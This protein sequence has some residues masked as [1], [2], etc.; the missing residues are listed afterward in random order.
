MATATETATFV[1]EYSY[2]AT[3]L[4]YL[5]PRWY[6]F[7]GVEPFSSKEAAEAFVAAKEAEYAER[8]ASPRGAEP[9]MFR[10]RTVQPA[11]E[12]FDEDAYWSQRYWADQ[13][14]AVRR[15]EE[16]REEMFRT[17]G[18][19]NVVR[20]VKGRKVPVG[21]EGTV[22]WLGEDKF[23]RT[24][25]YRVGFETAEGEKFFTALSNVEAVEV[26]A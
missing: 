6:T 9:C 24:G 20:V 25:A 18:R 4:D 16:A 2:E 21:T 8:F 10:V 26:G 1:A 3:T 7:E 19:G 12:Y 5:S 22:F 11:P 23:S 13:A 17:Y 14:R 15:V